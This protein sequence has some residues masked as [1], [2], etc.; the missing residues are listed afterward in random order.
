M[1]LISTSQ[2]KGQ[3]CDTKSLHKMSEVEVTFFVRQ[4]FQTI[5][6]TS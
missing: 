4:T 3:H 1:K 5:I 6:L 2:V